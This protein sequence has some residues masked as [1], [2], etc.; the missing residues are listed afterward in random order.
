MIKQLGLL[1]LGLFCA[2]SCVAQKSQPAALEFTKVLGV[3]PDLK[4]GA[5]SFETCAACH[6][7]DGSGLTDGTVPRLA[8]QHYR[9]LVKQ[10]VDFRHARRWDYR[11]EHFT[12]NHHLPQPED[13]ASVAAYA[14]Q[15]KP[16]AMSGT[17]TGEQL[18][19]G[20]RTYFSQC[21]ACHGTL[22]QGSDGRLVPRLAGQQYAYLV[23]Q[24]HDAADGRRPNMSATHQR[25]MRGLDKAQIDGV[26]DYLSRSLDAAS[27]S[28]IVSP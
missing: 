24:L 20:A 26:S 14:A 25:L 28:R 2:G 21:Q 27:G 22:G 12:D 13:V 16:A 1:A 15:L 4:R 5:E 10:L 9:V 8:G 6:G 7:A 23:R 19:I 17:G 18:A 11:M 3:Q